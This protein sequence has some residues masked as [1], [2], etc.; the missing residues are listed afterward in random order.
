MK[1]SGL[2]WVRPCSA[3]HPLRHRIMT[4]FK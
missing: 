2:P 3:P 4:N 1:V